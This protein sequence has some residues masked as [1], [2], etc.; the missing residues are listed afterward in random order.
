MVEQLGRRS[1]AEQHQQASVAFRLQYAIR[2][3]AHG[4]LEAD[5]TVPN[6]GV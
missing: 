1:I 4:A 2:Q 3:R 5:R 6:D